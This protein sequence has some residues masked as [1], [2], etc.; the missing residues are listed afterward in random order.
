MSDFDGLKFQPDDILRASDLQAIVDQIRGSGWGSGGGGEVDAMSDRR[1]RWHVAVRQRLAF[2]GKANGN[3]SAASGTAWGTGQ[4]TRWEFDNVAN[5]E[6]ATTAVFN[7]YNPSNNT[8]TGGAGI[9]SG[10]RCFV[11]EDESG[12]LIVSPLECS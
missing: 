10:L 5:N 1:G 2:V 6:Y 12:H 8:M 11:Q 4:V 3:I 9:T 7:V